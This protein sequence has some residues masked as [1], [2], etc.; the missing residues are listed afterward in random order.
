MGERIEVDAVV[1]RERRVG[2][3]RRLDDDGGVQERRRSDRRS[4]LRGEL[5]E[6]R[7]SA[8]ASDEAVHRGVEEQGR[9]A[10][11][12][13]DLVALGKGEEF[14]QALADSADLV[15]DRRLAVARAEQRRSDGREALNGLLANLGG[16][17]AEAAVV[18]KKLGR[19]GD[20][21]RHESAIP[22]SAGLYLWLS[23]GPIGR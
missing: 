11:A 6:H 4:E 1:R 3:C 15:D 10:V 2:T 7:V 19:D 23:T 20:R 12:Q 14:P 8:A 9:A 22:S 18:R 16:A 5:A 21:H 13:H 17:G